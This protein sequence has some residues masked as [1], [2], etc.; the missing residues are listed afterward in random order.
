MKNRIRTAK[1]NRNRGVR[2]LLMMLGLSMVGLT[3]KPF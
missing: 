1:S 3:Q 2:A